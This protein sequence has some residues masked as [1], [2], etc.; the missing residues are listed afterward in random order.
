MVK[1]KIVIQK[2]LLNDTATSGYH[3]VH[4]LKKTPNGATGYNTGFGFSDGTY[5]SQYTA[6]M[7]NYTYFYVYGVSIRYLPA[8]FGQSA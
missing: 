4:L 8:V 5:N 6:M 7:R 1:E 3:N 2:P